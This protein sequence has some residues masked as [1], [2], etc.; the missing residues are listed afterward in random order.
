MHVTKEDLGALLLSI[1]SRRQL[2]ANAAMAASPSSIA[3]CVGVRPVRR[4]YRGGIG[5]EDAAHNGAVGEHVEIVVIP[6]AGGARGRR[7][8]DKQCGHAREPRKSF[9]CRCSN[10]LI[11]AGGIYSME[12]ELAAL[13]QGADRVGPSKKRAPPAPVRMPEMWNRYGRSGQHRAYYGRAR[14]GRV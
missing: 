10:E 14:S 12:R 6:L 2:L 13:T 7:A 5:P 11:S 1:Y 9:F 4:S 8:F 3:T